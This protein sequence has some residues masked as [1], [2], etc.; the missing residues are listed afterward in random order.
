[1]FDSLFTVFVATVIV[2]IFSTATSYFNGLGFLV[3]V[4]C[5][6]MIERNIDHLIQWLVMV[7]YGITG[8]LWA[9]CVSL[10]MPSPLASFAFAAGYQVILFLVR[11]ARDGR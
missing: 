4:F 8:T 6:G 11:P 7:L 2:I 5:P 9:Y 1:M 10:F 3:R